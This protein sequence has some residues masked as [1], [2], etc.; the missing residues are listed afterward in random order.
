MLTGGIAQV[1]LR[2]GDT[3]STFGLA[4]LRPVIS[5]IISFIEAELCIFILKPVG[6]PIR[7]AVSGFAT[8]YTAEGIV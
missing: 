2:A 4:Q 3:Q 8:F 7:C 6:L 5:I 1:L